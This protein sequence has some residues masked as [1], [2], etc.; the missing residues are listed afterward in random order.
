[1]RIAAAP[2]THILAALA[3]LC[4]SL[5]AFS[6]APAAQASLR[7][8]LQERRLAKKKAERRIR[9]RKLRSTRSTKKRPVTSR[10]GYDRES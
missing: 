9:R 2:S 5:P 4:L 7:D 10:G 1:M 3:V 8:R 6:Q